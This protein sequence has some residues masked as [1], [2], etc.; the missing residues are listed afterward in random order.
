MKLTNKILKETIDKTVKKVLKEKKEQQ[1]DI[2]VENVLK[3]QLSILSEDKK[4]KNNNKDENKKRAVIQWLNRPE[5]DKAEIR[6]K[7]EGEPESQEEED[8]KRSYFM[9][10]VN[11]SYGK[12]FT[13]EEINKLYS[14]K[15]SLGQ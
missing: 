2:I 11:Q 12:N 14:I 7:L 6:R 1:I 4:T 3:E 13:D 8:S 10:K 15:T 5:I 9:K